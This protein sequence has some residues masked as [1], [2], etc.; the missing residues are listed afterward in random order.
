MISKTAGELSN[1]AKKDTTNYNMLEVGHAVTDD[2]LKELRKCRE[3][4]NKIFDEDE[5]CLVRQCASDPLIS[6]AKRYKYYAFL[7][8]P[9]PR[10][11]QTVFLYNKPLDLIKKRLW[12][13]PS[14]ARMAQLAS[15]TCIVDKKYNE[16]Q[17]WSVAFFK[18]TFWDFIRYQHG[19][20]M[21]SESEYISA[22]REELV[23]AGCKIPSSNTSDPFDFSKIHIKKV[24]DPQKSL[25]D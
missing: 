11:D 21:L 20:D 17:A 25:L 13:L 14:A 4:H 19:I 2:V 5:Y 16:M 8:L 22:H 12:T 18:G 10:P 24:V 3:I 7:Y 9:Q 15:T 1:Q 6:N 23:K